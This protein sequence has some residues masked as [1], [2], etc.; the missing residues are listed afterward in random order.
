VLVLA[1][2]GLAAFGSRELRAAW[3]VG[4]LALGLLGSGWL[5]RRRWIGVV[6][7]RRIDPAALAAIRDA[8]SAAIVINPTGRLLFASSAATELLRYPPDALTDVSLRE[9]VSPADSAAILDLVG[10]PAG[11]RRQVDCRFR[12]GDREWLSV[13]LNI[14]NLIADPSVRGL[15]ASIHDV[16]RWKDLEDSLTE[17]AFHDSLTQLPNRALFIDRLEHALGR[18]RRHARGTAVLFVDLDDFKTVNDSLGHVE[19]D[20]ALKMVGQRLVQSIRPEDTA[21]RL[22]GDEFAILLDDVDE[23]DAAT[24]AAR[25]MSTLEA[26][27]VLPE[28]AIRIGASI[29]I[30]HSAAGLTRSTD[31]LRAAD[32]A[33]YHAKESGKGQFRLFD[34]SMQDASTERLSLGVD[35]RGAVERGEFTLHYQPIVELPDGN[36]VAMEALVRWMH[37]ERGLIPPTEFIPIAEKTGLMVPIGEFVIQEAC[38]QARTWQLARAGLPPVS[39]NVNLS[40]VQLQH[41]GLVAAVSLALEDSDLSP[42]LLTLEIT[43]SVVARE[44]EATARRLRQLK[45][46]GVALAIDDFGT[47]FSSLSYLRRFP[48]EVVKIDKSFIDGIADDMGAQSLARGVIQLAHSLKTIAVAEG[49]ETEA[50]AKRLIRMGC[51]RAQGS[52][53]ARPMDAREA[54]EY[55]VGRSILTL[56]VGHVGPELN[57]IKAVVADFER[58]NPDLKVE[59]VGGASDER[60]QAA[61]ESDDPPTVVSS[62][63]SDTFGSSR[64]VS[65]LVDLGPLMAR[66]GITDADFIEATLAYTGDDRGRWALPVLADTYGLLFNREQFARAGV[67][68]PPRTIDELTELAKRLTVRNQDGSLRVVGFDPTM[69]FYENTLATF[70]HLFGASWQTD[71]R[72][73]LGSDPAWAKLLRWQKELVDWYGREDLE[74]FHAEIGDE[75]SPRNPFQIGK[76]AMCLDGEWRVAFIAIEA[77]ELDYGTAPLPVDASRAELYGSGYINGSV[78]GIPTNARH[79]EAGWKLVKYL[80]TDEAALAKLSNGLRNVPSTR[81]SLRSP[82]LVEDERFAVFLDIFAHEYSATAPMTPIGSD[83]QAMADE[84]AVRWEAGDVPDIEAALKELDGAIDEKIRAAVAE[85]GRT[86]AA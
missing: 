60:I 7:V 26:P 64:S 28:R 22:G 73:S 67:S 58:L 4:A 65:K 74:A 53:F 21:G 25:V 9:L 80:A 69:G 32:V 68:A 35:M 14:T 39:V 13:E 50:Q 18:R 76:L 38:R 79:R 81:A 17:L 40:G 31:M 3:I 54:T 6:R 23:E 15:V 47:G 43:E 52:R 27:F 56:W 16:T 66:D 85:L 5:L 42:E 8:A 61:L 37:A 84:L 19:A 77:D 29:G 51:D 82:A 78:I 63:E 83:Y 86:R 49:V 1:F 75:F 11:A 36:V 33:M 24:V 48:I 41:P 2:V 55:V 12:M 34:A 70:G 57:I 71:G 10:G 46:L 30:A 44:T 62:F 59:V 72:S 45:G 20:A